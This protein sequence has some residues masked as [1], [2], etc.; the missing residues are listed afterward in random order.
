MIGQSIL[1]FR[2]D[3]LKESELFFNLIKKE[4]I[5]SKIQDIKKI[6]ELF[7][8]YIDKLTMENKLNENTALIYKEVVPLFEAFYVFY[9]KELKYNSIKDYLNKNML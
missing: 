4:L 6:R 5:K 8:L 7:N 2:Y 1:F 9:D 3:Y